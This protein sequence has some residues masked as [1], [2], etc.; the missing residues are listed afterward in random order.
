V[1]PADAD[2]L[3]ALP[4]D[5]SRIGIRELALR[6][7]VTLRKLGPVLDRLERRGLIDVH[8]PG[9]GGERTV[10]LDGR[11]AEVWRERAVT[12]EGRLETLITA[13]ELAAARLLRAIEAARGVE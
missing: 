2:I 4:Q 13:S 12:A 5:R 6:L 10:A 1:T 7:G 8:H 3:A 9:P 11:P